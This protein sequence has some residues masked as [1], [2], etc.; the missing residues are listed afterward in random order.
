MWN[1]TCLTVTTWLRE[2]SLTITVGRC[3]SLYIHSVVI[4]ALIWWHAIDQ[5][6]IYS[7]EKVT[8]VIYNCRKWWHI[9]I[10]HYNVY[11]F[12][13]L[14]WVIVY[15][16]ALNVNVSIIQ[17][18]FAKMCFSSQPFHCTTLPSSSY[19]ILFILIPFRVN[20]S[21][22]DGNTVKYHQ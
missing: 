12:A 11:L 2:F 18:C 21:V 16:D 13:F 9:H 22:V 17:R 14:P 20:V 15:I 19:E 1:D 10:A 6:M 3:M 8:R 5:A 4:Q 7:S